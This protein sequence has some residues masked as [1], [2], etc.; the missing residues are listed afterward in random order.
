MFG[1]GAIPLAPADSTQC[2][3]RILRLMI[4]AI[5]ARQD[6]CSVEWCGD[7]LG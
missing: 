1:R 2:M 3:H 5:N 4:V 6:Y 7:P